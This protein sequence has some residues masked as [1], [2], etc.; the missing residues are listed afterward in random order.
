MQEGVA[1]EAIS[2]AGHLKLNNLAIIYDNNQITCD[3]SVDMTNTEDINTKMRATGWNVIDV[4]D[5]CFDVEGLVLA[6]T[7]ARDLSEKPTFINVRTVIGLG[8]SL[9]G[10]SLAHGDAFGVDDVARMKQ[11]CGFDPNEHF[12]IPESVKHF[13][14]DTVPRGQ[15]NVKR[16]EKLFEDYSHSYPN[17][18]D[19]LSARL[20]GDLPTDWKLHIPTSFPMEPTPSRIS[21]GLVFSPV[22]ERIRTF[23]VGSAD[24]SD[25]VLI[26][27]EGM[28]DFQHSDLKTQC[29]ING[30][31]HGRYIRYGVREHA[32][33]A[34]ANGI[35]AYHPNTIIPATSS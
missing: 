21:S 26:N 34:I 29:G 5:G 20:R 11:E 35:A 31:Y 32:M 14:A 2:F 18:A 1:L 30:T 24:L 8:S 28:E 15:E 12:A 13:F 10:T 23:M 33:A 25:D 4:E 27:F 22:F 9:E 16:W 19:E 7:Q 3:G 6:L 17:L